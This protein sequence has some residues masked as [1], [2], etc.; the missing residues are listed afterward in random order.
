MNRFL[1]A[2]HQPALIRSA[3]WEASSS[4]RWLWR[5]M[6]SRRKESTNQFSRSAG[7]SL[8]GMVTRTVASVVSTV[9]KLYRASFSGKKQTQECDAHRAVCV[10]FVAGVSDFLILILIIILILIFRGRLRLRLG[11]GLRGDPHNAKCAR[12][13]RSINAGAGAGGGLC[14]GFDG[15]PAGAVPSAWATRS[16]AKWTAPVPAIFSIATNPVPA[17][18]QCAATNCATR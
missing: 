4:V 7:T 17:R 8:F 15:I 16:P 1:L 18:G 11:L 3:R 13:T 5:A 6:A 12:S 2:A 10:H 9:I 14:G